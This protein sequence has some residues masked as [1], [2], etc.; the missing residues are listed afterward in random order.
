MR[1]RG[2]Q[3]T[4]R[5]R[6]RGDGIWAGNYG[7]AGAINLFGPKLGCPRRIRGTRTI[8]T[9]ASTAVYKT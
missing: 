9:G 2:L 7:E 3:L 5:G 8:G 1:L 6:A 4:A